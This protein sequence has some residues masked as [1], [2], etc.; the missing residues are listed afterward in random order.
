MHIDIY[1]VLL[2]LLVLRNDE[3][4]VF[5]LNTGIAYVCVWCGVCVCGV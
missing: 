3:M 5:V 4:F 2:L 1:I